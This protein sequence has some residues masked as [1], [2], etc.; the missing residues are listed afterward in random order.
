[1]LYIQSYCTA[2][3][4]NI[5][6]KVVRNYR[7]FQLYLHM[8]LLDTLKAVNLFLCRGNERW[9]EISEIDSLR[10]HCMIAILHAHLYVFLIIYSSVNYVFQNFRYNSAKEEK[11]STKI[12]FQHLLLY[13]ICKYI[14][15]YAFLCTHKH[16]ETHTG[17]YTHT[18]KVFIHM[19]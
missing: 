16:T 15:M 10:T 8:E 5:H 19:F 2:N 12:I 13:I 9:G 18:V 14:Y 3:Y 1:M 6:V 11:L 17:T 7:T 4:L